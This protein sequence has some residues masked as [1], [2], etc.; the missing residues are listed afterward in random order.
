MK[1]NVDKYII[2]KSCETNYELI[3]VLTHLG[4]SG[5]SGHFIAYCKSPVDKNWYCYNDAQ[6]TEC[7]NDV[8][9]KINSNGIPY[10]LFYQRI[11]INIVSQNVNINSVQN[12]FVLYFTYND[13]EGYIDIKEDTQLLNIINKIYNKYTWLP[14]QGV[15]YFVK[16]NENLVEL[17][18]NEYLSKS[19]LKNG[20]KII[21]A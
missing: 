4:P 10:V 20:D 8:E 5:M 16:K 18:M 3:G 15:G 11:N 12:L 21:I 17:N 6:V 13:K 9:N 19:K 2:D 7:Y 1:L 14:K